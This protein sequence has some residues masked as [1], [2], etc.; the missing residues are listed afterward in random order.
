MTPNVVTIVLDDLGFAQLS[1][2]GS[3]INTPNIDRLAAGGL[4][5]NRFHV[6]A[7]CSPTRASLLTGR[8]HH[9][10]G[11][12]FLVDIPF[13]DPGYT[14]RLAKTA[15]TLP[16]LLRDNDYATMAVGKWHL[17]PRGERSYAGPFTR[18]P[19]GV[20][21]ESYYGFLQGATNHWD[22]NLVRDNHYVNPP[23][24]PDEGYHLTED[25]ADAAI[26]GIIDR[27][28]A[29][30]GKPFYLYFA[31]GAPHAPHHVTPQWSDPYAGM[32]DDGWDRWR[33][34]TFARQQ[35]LGVVPEGTTLTPRPPWVPAWDDLDA[36]SRRLYSRMHEV[37]AGFVTHTD[38][39]IGRIIDSLNEQGIL[40]ETI[41][42]VLSDNGASAE[43]GHIG[44]FNQ[45]RFT[46]GMPE[47]MSANLE[48][49]DDWGGHRTYSHYS[50][51]WAWAG[52]TPLRLWKRY[53]WLGGSRTPLVVHW[54][55]GIRAQGEVRDQFCHVIDLMPTILE[56]CGVEVPDTV[57][58]VAQQPIDGAS[59]SA[60]FSNPGAPAPRSVQ[61]FE[62]LGSRSIVSGPWK[63]TTDHV[64]SGVPDEEQMLEGSRS[65][66]DDHWALFN[67]ADDF[68]EARDV[69]AGHPEVVAELIARW[70]EEA[71]RNNV[72][73][74]C[75]SLVDRLDRITGFRF[76]A[77]PRS[78]FLPTGSPIRDESV[79]FLAGGG[80]ITAVVEVPESPEGVL[81]ALGD[82]VSG[83]ALFVDRGRLTA[84][85]TIGGDITTVIADGDVPSGPGELGMVL[86]TRPD[87]GTDIEVLHGDVVVGTGQSEHAPPFSW[88]HGGTALCLG[89]DQGFP[90]SDQY[91]PPFPWNGQL[92]CVIVEA[93]LRPAPTVEDVRD[94]LNSD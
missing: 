62:M 67:L 28:Q 50:W 75:D 7:L 30:P 43:G 24:T 52:N 91:K 48:H 93:P 84:S 81:C 19:L 38:A 83:F 74:M 86:R 9:A 6:T 13:S 79:P 88:Q 4:R 29:A 16:R 14:G 17:T 34:R 66:D 26:S 68:S 76:P 87:G 63:A 54:P 12:G 73:P 44:S 22:P 82:W 58:G 60:T 3:D 1:C 56:A 37:Y 32:F 41:V 42:M 70:E 27:R 35:A 65:F 5:Y 15:A 53:T 25:L 57:D 21:F 90:V 8:N 23:R 94:S 18:W 78:V 33:E 46:Q 89:F 49:L 10:V 55:E 64:S 59:L 31:T 2:F 39:Q 71:E 80:R 77:Q 20:G 85:V 40:D 69:S 47:S 11:V 72:L 36:D 51:G 45:H 92:D 61:Y